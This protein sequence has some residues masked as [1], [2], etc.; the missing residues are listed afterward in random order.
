MQIKP[1]KYLAKEYRN[2]NNAGKH[3][4]PEGAVGFGIRV[5]VEVHH[6]TNTNTNPTNTIITPNITNPC[7]D[8]LHR[9]A[10]WSASI[11]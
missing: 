4:E 2:K 7:T 5:G 6:L 10:Q 8:L 1:D 9:F 3:N 11:N